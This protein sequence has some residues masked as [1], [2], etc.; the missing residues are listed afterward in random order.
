MDDNIFKLILGLIPV[1]GTVITYF[2]IPFF[3]SKISGEKL[4]QYRKWASLAVK[5]SEMLWTESG[6]GADKKSYAVSFLDRLFNSKKTVIS[7][8]Q[9]NIL[10]EAAVQELNAAKGAP[11]K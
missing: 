11:E 4:E 1:I 6:S 10:I 9:L 5:A 3:K 7:K 2:V 8:Q